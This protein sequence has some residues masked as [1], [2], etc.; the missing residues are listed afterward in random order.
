MRSCNVRSKVAI[1]AIG[2]AETH[3]NIG[4][5]AIIELLNTNASFTASCG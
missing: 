5:V 4:V 2:V 3:G 1:C